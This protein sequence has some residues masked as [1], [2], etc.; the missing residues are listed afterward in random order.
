M[1]TNRRGRVRIGLAKGKE[2]CHVTSSY[3]FWW[4]RWLEYLGV[5]AFSASG[6]MKGIRKQMDP[7]GVVILGLFE[8]TGGG[9]MRDL[10]LGITPPSMFRDPTYALIAITTAVVMTISPLRRTMTRNAEAFDRTMFLLDTVGL[11]MFTVIGVRTT[12][13][14]YPSTGIFA[15]LFVGVT[16]GVGGGTIRD[17]LAGEIPMIFTKHVYALACL[18]GAAVCALLWKA[19]PSWAMLAGAAT[20]IVLR[21]LARHY[22]WNLPQSKL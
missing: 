20:V 22:R 7:F 12:I 19:S 2:G 16:A 13:A 1:L 6:A 21:V 5:V 10:L 15:M 9:V 8:A 18:A 4:M 17:V 11:G 3:W 14:A